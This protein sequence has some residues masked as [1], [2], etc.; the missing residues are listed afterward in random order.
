MLNIL[1][2]PVPRELAFGM[3]GVAE[4]CTVEDSMCMEPTAAVRVQGEVSEEL[5]V[6]L[7]EESAS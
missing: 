3:I 2:C 5:E 1:P 7:T 4:R 6:G